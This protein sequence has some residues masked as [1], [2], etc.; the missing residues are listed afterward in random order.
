MPVDAVLNLSRK[1]AI[2]QTTA[3]DQIFKKQPVYP[4]PVECGYSK[5]GS[6]LTPTLNNQITEVIVNQSVIELLEVAV[7]ELN[8]VYENEAENAEVESE[9]LEDH[10]D[11]DIES[12]HL[13]CDCGD[14]RNVSEALT[15]LKNFSHEDYDNNNHAE[16]DDELFNDEDIYCQGFIDYEPADYK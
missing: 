3:Y 8:E 2:Y 9:D 6:H 13:I 14:Y 4:D 7:T 10:S 5:V 1:R 12:D 15:I 11:N 16:N